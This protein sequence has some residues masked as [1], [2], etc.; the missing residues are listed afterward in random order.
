MLLRRTSRSSGAAVLGTFLACA[1]V[2]GP[3]LAS[4]QPTRGPHRPS[5]AIEIAR[6]VPWYLRHTRHEP[7]VGHLVPPRSHAAIVGGTS[8]AQG[9]FAFMAFILYF[10]SSGNP[11]FLCSGTVLARNVVL[12]AGH[13]GIDETTN[14]PLDPAGYAVITGSV[15]WTNQ[16]LRQVSG[17]SSVLVDPGYDPAAAN[18]DAS[19]LILSTP[20]TAPPVRL[21][22]A[23][24]QWL[25]AAGTGTYIAGWGDQYQ[26][27][28]TATV[29]LWAGTVVQSAAYC[30]QFTWSNYNQTFQACAAD[31]PYDDTATCNGDSGGPLLATDSAGAPVEIGITSYGPVDCDTVTASYFTTAR[32]VSQWADGI[33][34]SLNPPPAPAPPP[35]PPPPKPPAPQPTLPAMTKAQ[36]KSFNNQTLSGFEDRTYNRGHQRH[37]TCTRKSNVKFSCNTYWWYG[38]NDYAATVELWYSWGSGTDVYWN[39]HYSLEWV[40][41]QCYNHS[42]HRN[43]CAIHH[44]TGV[45]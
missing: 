28:P 14:A 24:D 26:N 40:N 17:V 13:C 31:Y 41:D 27:S 36:A 16:S 7:S 29:L 22:T 37:I 21:A 45:Y 42:R 10:D 32:T 1:M 30:G 2:A 20:T 3:A 5:L 9:S 12:T 8:A 44:K 15:D 35:A 18:E 34:T 43:R 25:E 39:D 11:L 23:A 38:P 4:P 33:V 6:A 19:L